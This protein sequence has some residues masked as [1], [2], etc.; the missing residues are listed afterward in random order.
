MKK[1]TLNIFRMHGWRVDHAIHNY[2]YFVFYDKYVKTFLA[3]GRYIMKLLGP[4]RINSL[5][6]KTI[7]ENYHAKVLT[8]GDARKILSLNRDLTMDAGRAKKIIPFSAAN[9]VIFSQPDF[10][11]VMDCPCRL[12]RKEHCEPVN[13]CMAVGRTTAE[14]WLDHCAQYHVRR[15]TQAQ[16]LGLLEESAR[17]NRVITAW[18][19]T[20][21]GGRTGVIC[22]CCSCCCGGIEGM[23]LAR[24][25]PGDVKVTNMISS[26][27][28]V[29]ID[30]GACISCGTC[31]D[32]CA[33]DACRQVE[34]GSPV[35]N[36]EAC[37]GC[38]VCVS[39]CPSGARRMVL[40]AGKGV[41]LDV[42]SANV[43]TGT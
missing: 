19:K 7:F 26:G 38:G 34:G 29:A 24:R 36:W 1:S 20:E 22:S 4:G 14:F 32:V 12:S 27:Y 39:K 18:L 6:F 17:L 21:T 33:F 10:I 11:A 16:A 9:K 3:S 42:G 41:P 15:I 25:L 13:V 30:T 40:D 35:Y 43:E 31:V 5:T 23:K 37:L 2:V 8:P 28:S